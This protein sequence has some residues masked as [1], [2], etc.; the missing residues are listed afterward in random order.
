MVG[1]VVVGS[2]VVE[3]EE[4]DVDVDDDVVVVVV[5]VVVGVIWASF[6]SKFS[7]AGSTS[8]LWGL[9]TRLN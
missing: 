8:P 7:L 9:M 6:N 5:V 1:L 2:R 3:G 4:L